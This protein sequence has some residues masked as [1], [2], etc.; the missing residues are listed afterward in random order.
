VTKAGWTRENVRHVAAMLRY[1][2]HPAVTV[3]D[4][5][6]EDFFLALAPGWLNLGLW[7]GDGSEPAEAQIAVRRLVETMAGSLPKSGAV[8]DVGNGLAAQDPLIANVAA[9]KSLVALNITRSQ[10]VAGKDRLAEA[11]AVPVNGDATRLPFTDRSFDG[12]ISVEAAFHFASRARFFVE[13]YRVL[14]PGGVLS[15]S[16]IPT[17][18]YPRGPRELVAAVSQLRVWGLG[19]YAAATPVEIVRWVEDAG[20]VDVRADLV[21]E[22]VIEPALRCIRDRLRTSRDEATGSYRLAASIMVSQVELLWKRGM[23]DYLLLGATK[24]DHG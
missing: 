23:I 24:P 20:F 19:T 17:Y 3:Y 16:D 18:R 4:S 12:V 21:G 7:E 15:M 2:R 9:T 10:L 5:I 6:G 14:R 8:L 1:R 22:R 13:A 11:G